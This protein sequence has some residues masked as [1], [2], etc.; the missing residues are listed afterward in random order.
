MFRSVSKQET[1]HADKTPVRLRQAR[2]TD[3][4]RPYTCPRRRG[5][6]DKDDH[7]EWTVVRGARL[8]DAIPS[9]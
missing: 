6:R 1:R 3:Y 2:E 7:L 8:C 5:A 9:T 4:V